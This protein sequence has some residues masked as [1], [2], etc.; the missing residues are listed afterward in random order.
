MSHPIDRLR[1]R[2][3]RLL[4]LIEQ[5][6]SLREVAA[7]LHLT[8]PAVSQI[9]KDLELSLGSTLVERSASGVKLS[10]SGRLAL[11]R[12]SAGLAVFEELARELKLD[13]PTLRLGA[14]PALLHSF[15]PAVLRQ[16]D[17]DIS[18][19]N[20]RIKTGTASVM[21]S[22]LCEGDIDAYIGVVD[23][24]HMNGTQWDRLTHVPLRLTP[25]SIVCSAQHP[26]AK[27]T[28]L[29]AEDLLDC[30]WV[31]NPEGS[32]TRTRLEEAF[33]NVGSAAPRAKMELHADPSA[34]LSMIAGTR[35]LACV[36]RAVLQSYNLSQTWCELHVE[37]IA[38]QAFATNLVYF[39]EL[40]TLQPLLALQEAL[41]SHANEFS[42]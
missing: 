14:N 25:L 40:S 41:Q 33:L 37:D 6:R 39:Q 5:H 22:A 11:Q 35:M 38:I 18:S 30:T 15:I 21:M 9:L 2:H 20:M 31:L 36:P 8:Q 12:A 19:L 28:D 7:V 13:L 17:F 29:Q 23:W 16:M 10:S 42:N 32:F 27:R 1:L 26:L 3:L 34:T 24:Q 4:S